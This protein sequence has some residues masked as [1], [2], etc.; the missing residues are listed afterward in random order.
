MSPRRLCRELN[1][2][3]S[4]TKTRWFFRLPLFRPVFC[5]RFRCFSASCSHCLA[6][7][8]SVDF[9]ERFGESFAGSRSANQRMI[10]TVYLYRSNN[11]KCALMSWVNVCKHCIGCLRFTGLTVHEILSDSRSGS[12]IFSFFQHVII[13]LILIGQG[14]ANNALKL[15]VVFRQRQIAYWFRICWQ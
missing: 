1:R 8:R 10:E 13:V 14:Q 7:R 5:F 12:A 3:E 4:S 15:Y 2:V 6:A 11:D 9:S